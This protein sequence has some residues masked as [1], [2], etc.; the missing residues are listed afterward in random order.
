MG[1]L[2]GR[3]RDPRTGQCGQEAFEVG[4]HGPAQPLVDAVEMA[5]PAPAFRHRALARPGSPVHRGGRARRAWHRGR[6]GSACS[7][8]RGARSRSASAASKAATS[9]SH[10]SVETSSGLDQHADSEPARPSP[11]WREVS[12]RAARRAPR[13]VATSAPIGLTAASFRTP[14]K[15]ALEQVVVAGVKVAVEHEE[16]DHRAH[17]A[18]VRPA[19]KRAAGRQSPGGR[20]SVGA[21]SSL[22]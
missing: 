3:P 9:S 5:V 20:G 21:D 10:S 4:D 6:F 7:H 22:Q 15:P 14:V 2:A 13:N 17:V 8:G 12:S 11:L 1:E 18:G 16:V 19:E